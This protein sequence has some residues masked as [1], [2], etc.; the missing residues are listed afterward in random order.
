MQLGANTLRSVAV[1]S[2]NGYFADGVA[3]KPWVD[4]SLTAKRDFWNAQN[5]WYPTWQKDG[6]M[7]VKSVKMFQEAGYNGCKA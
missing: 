5:E 2:T 6:Q 1:G 4:E 7:I 3:G